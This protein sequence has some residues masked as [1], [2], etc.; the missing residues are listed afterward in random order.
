MLET[1]KKGK[2]KK[3]DPLEAYT[4][5]LVERAS[6]GKLDPLIGRELEM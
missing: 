6:Q 1:D 2:K 5:D 3:S 4:I